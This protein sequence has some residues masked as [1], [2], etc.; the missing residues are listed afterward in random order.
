MSTPIIPTGGGFNARLANDEP[1]KDLPREDLA[2]SRPQYRPVK[3]Y[4]ESGVGDR[5]LPT[6]REFSESFDESLLLSRLNDAVLAGELSNEQ[7]NGIASRLG[8]GRARD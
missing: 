3:E 7:A 4:P 2:P 1:K 6:F 5:L 8:L